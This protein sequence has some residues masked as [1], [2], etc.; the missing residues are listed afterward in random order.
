MSPPLVLCSSCQAQIYIVDTEL[1][2]RMPIDAKPRDDG[3][4]IFIDKKAHV[5]HKGEE[6]PDGK[7]RWVSHFATCTKPKKHRRTLARRRS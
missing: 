6:A 2:K 7:L 4:I 1:G 5:L 3:N